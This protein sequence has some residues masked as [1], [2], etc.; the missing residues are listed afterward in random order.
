MGLFSKFENKMEDSIE[1]GGGLFKTP[2]TPVK[3]TR[4][5]E[6]QMHRNLT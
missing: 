6:K 4:E 5:A 3:I 1:G 2:I